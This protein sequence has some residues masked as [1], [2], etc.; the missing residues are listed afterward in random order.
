MDCTEIVEQQVPERYLLH[1]LTE[2]EQD[3]FERHYFEC[4]ECFDRVCA[5]KA[6]QEVH[7]VDKS[8]WP[9]NQFA[10][11]RKIS[12]GWITSLVILGLVVGSVLGA[13]RYR[14]A[15]NETAT[16]ASHEEVLAAR[17]SQTPPSTSADSSL[18]SELGRVDPPPYS[19]VVLRGSEDRAGERFRDAMEHYRQKEYAAAIPGLQQVL[20]VDRN[21]ANANFYLG[22]CYLL[23]DQNDLA[24]PP[25]QK[26]ISLHDLDYAEQAHFYLAKAFIRKNDVNAA[27]RELELTIQLH[28]DRESEARKLKQQVISRI[29]ATH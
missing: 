14:R 10:A 7:R 15:H 25:L 1:D 11:Y 9:Q 24:I 2:S 3:A 20:Q 29:Q 13:L 28:S 17:T 27:E 19:P 5:A 18:I 26:T 8:S 21:A 22:A 23:I 4:K 6:I 12:R 16:R